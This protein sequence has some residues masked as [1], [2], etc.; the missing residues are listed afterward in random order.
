MCSRGSW[1]CSSSR[2]FPQRQLLPALVVFRAVYYLLPLSIALIGL[3]LDEAWRRR[4]HVGRM[5]A[6]AGRWTEQLTPHVLAIFTFLAGLLLLFS[7]ATSSGAW[8]FGTPRS[9]P[10]AGMIELSHFL[11]SVVGAVLLVLSQGLARRLDAAYYMT[12]AAMIVGMAASLLKGF[13]Y[14]E[15]TPA[16][17]RADG[18]VAGATSVRP[19]R[20]VL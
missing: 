16:V 14:E 8:A 12:A 3:V 10:A 2:T 1:S 20:G 19:P 15:A 7:G 11:G 17:P 9:D 4:A 13:D 6:A 18:A 5:A